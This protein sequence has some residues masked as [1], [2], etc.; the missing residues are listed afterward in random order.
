MAIL[1]IEAVIFDWGG[2]LTP[3]HDIDLYGQWYAYAEVF[4]PVNAASLARKLTEAEKTRWQDQRNSSGGSSAGAL[5]SIFLEFGIDITG[6]AHLRALSVYLDFWAPHTLAYPDAIELFRGL[7]TDGLRIGILSNTLWPRNHHF[8]VFERDNL[9]EFIDAAAYTSEMTVAKPHSEAFRSI[10]RSL[11]TTTL[12]SV[13]VGDR[14][15]EDIHGSQ[16]VGMKAIW[17]P[18][19]TIPDVEAVHTKTVPDAIAYE[20]IEVLEI[21]RRWRAG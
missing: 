8:E 12:Q 18:H 9:A 3:W 5:D 13:F 2:T 7:R 17:I 6:V 11:G 16:Q 4:D 15:W 20:L 14:I 19:S 1:D 10:A 21:V